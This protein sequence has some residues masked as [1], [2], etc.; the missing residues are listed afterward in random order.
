MGAWSRIS[1]ATAFLWPILVFALPIMAIVFLIAPANTPSLVDIQAN[2]SWNLIFSYYFTVNI[3]VVEYFVEFLHIFNTVTPWNQVVISV[4]L[5]YWFK[6]PKYAFFGY[7]LMTAG[8]PMLI[9]GEIML[10]FF[11]DEYGVSSAVN[12][13]I[14]D[15]NED[16]FTVNTS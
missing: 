13:L 7:S 3:E 4:L 11:P 6:L 2:W 8:L 14:Q 16:G 15:A 9:F 5:S 12:Q 10:A 1:V